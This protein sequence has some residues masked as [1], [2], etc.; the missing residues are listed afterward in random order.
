MDLG[1]DEVC[2]VSF[3]ALWIMDSKKLRVHE[4]K[5]KDSEF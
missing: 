2:E 3:H 5:Q 4:T 1:L